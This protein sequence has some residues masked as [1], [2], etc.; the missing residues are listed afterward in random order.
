MPKNIVNIEF[1]V[2]R[3]IKRSL[4]SVLINGHNYTNS[5]YPWFLWFIW[6][7]GILLI[8]LKYLMLG[9]EK[10]L[11]FFLFLVGIQDTTSFWSASQTMWLTRLWSCNGVHLKST[12]YPSTTME[13]VLS[14]L[15]FLFNWDSFDR[16]QN[17]CYAYLS[18]WF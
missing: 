2:S 3:L 5:Y 18:V 11:L 12:F 15:S 17:V 8:D 10:F 4:T 1:D 13:V 9:F 7:F 14:T 6:K 16:G